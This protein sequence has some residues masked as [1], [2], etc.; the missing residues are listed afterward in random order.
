M[1]IMRVIKGMAGFKQL[2][3]VMGMHLFNNSNS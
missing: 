3:L 1:F 2:P